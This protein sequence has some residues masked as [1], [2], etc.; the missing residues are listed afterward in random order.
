MFMFFTELKCHQ[1]HPSRWRET[2]L[3]Q[4]VTLEAKSLQ[5][6]TDLN[7]SPADEEQHHHH[8]HHPGDSSSH[9]YCSL[10]LSLELETRNLL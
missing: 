2:H 8:H 5:Q 7:G 1:W 6:D 9:C 4:D 3:I 10:C